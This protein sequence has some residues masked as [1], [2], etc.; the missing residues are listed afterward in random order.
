[1]CIDTACSSGLVALHTACQNLRAGT[2]TAAIVGGVRCIF[3]DSGQLLFGDSSLF[4]KSGTC[5]SFDADSDGFIRAEACGVLYL[6]P[7]DAAKRDGNPILGLVRGTGLSQS[8]DT[9]IMSPSITA[10][11]QA[12]NQALHSSGVK[13]GDVNYIEAHGTATPMGDAIEIEALQEAYGRSH[14]PDHPLI[15]GSVKANLG[16]SEWAS[17]I[18]S[19]IKVLLMMQKGQIPRLA[20]FKTA[21]PFIDLSAG[22]IKF[23][24]EVLPWESPRP[25]GLLAGV[26]ANGM[27]G[28]AAHAILEQ[29]RA[30]AHQQQPRAPHPLPFVLSAASLPILIEYAK[31]HLEFLRRTDRPHDF[32]SLCFTSCMGRPHYAYRLAVVANDIASLSR[33]LQ[34]CLGSESRLVAQPEDLNQGTALAL[35]TEFMRGDQPKWEEAFPGLDWQRV[36]L[37]PYPLEKKLI[38]I[39]SSSGRPKAV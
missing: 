29:Y 28:S 30:E 15:V 31:R 4:S 39:F 35:A 1:M 6:K 13:P 23:P 37:P 19:I 14:Q 3:G 5:R 7:L 21:H 33:G 25:G 8:G 36:A 18:I 38:W 24:Q 32:R 17:G 20:H 10:Q 12:I 26:S 16:H 2:A 27:T 22:L 34:Q 9:G 11:I